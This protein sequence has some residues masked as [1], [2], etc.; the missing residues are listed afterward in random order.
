MGSYHELGDVS[1]RYSEVL[2]V[3]F[4]SR[5][6]SYIGWHCR[7]GMLMAGYII[8]SRLYDEDDVSQIYAT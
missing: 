7:K 8:E 5:R 4:T 6:S 1:A 2:G 3:Q